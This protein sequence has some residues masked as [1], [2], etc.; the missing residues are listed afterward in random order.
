MPM[1]SASCVGFSLPVDSERCHANLV[2]PRHTRTKK[3]RPTIEPRI[4]QHL[5]P[6]GTT[7]TGML[8]ILDP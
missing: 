6:L 3:G 5:V 4:P 7:T 1:M 8:R 2:T